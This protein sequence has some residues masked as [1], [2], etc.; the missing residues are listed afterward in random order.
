MTTTDGAATASPPYPRFAV[1]RQEH[2]LSV[3]DVVDHAVERA[4]Y[5]PGIHVAAIRQ[6]PADLGEA[7]VLIVAAPVPGQQ[8]QRETVEGRMAEEIAQAAVG[9]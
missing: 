9:A 7:H 4:H 3:I 1:E 2:F 5:R 8:Q 6:Q